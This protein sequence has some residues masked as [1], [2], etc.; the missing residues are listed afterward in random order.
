M[1]NL[2]FETSINFI[3]AEHLIFVVIFFFLG[4]I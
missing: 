3:G 2:P 4:F 1:M